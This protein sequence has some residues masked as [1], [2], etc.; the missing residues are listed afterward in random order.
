MIEYDGELVDS[1]TL[2]ERYG[3]DTAPY[4]IH[5]NRDRYEDGALHRG[6]GTLVNQSPTANRTNARFGVRIE[7]YYLAPRTSETTK[8]SLSATEMNIGS[9]KTRSIPPNSF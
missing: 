9:M 3:D 2:E 8:K 4:G 6:V 1:T 5:I 7:S